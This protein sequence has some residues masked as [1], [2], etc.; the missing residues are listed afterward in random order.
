MALESELKFLS[1]QVLALMLP[2]DSEL[3]LLLVPELLLAS[4]SVFLVS[5]KVTFYMGD[6]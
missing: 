1:E 3:E 5:K 2:A 6:K 4:V